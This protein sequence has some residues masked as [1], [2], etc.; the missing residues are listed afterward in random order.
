M[1]SAKAQM[2]K[3]FSIKFREDI[4]KCSVDLSRLCAMGGLDP[5]VAPAII[6][7]E[8]MDLAI[9]VIVNFTTM[10]AERLAEH[11][12]HTFELHKKREAES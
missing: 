3:D 2:Q 8:C 9:G 5:R 1:T 7:A 11:C 6:S 4:V 10:P 12:R